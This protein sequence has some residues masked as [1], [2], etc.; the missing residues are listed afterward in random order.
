MKNAGYSLKSDFVCILRVFSV[1]RMKLWFCIILMNA[2]ILFGSAFTA[3]AMDYIAGVKGGYFI[4][5]AWLN[6]AGFDSKKGD[7]AL[8]GPVFSAMVTDDLSLSVAGLFGKQSTDWKSEEV[9]GS[10][11]V[12]GSNSFHVKRYDLDTAFNYSFTGNFKIFGG[13]KYQYEKIKF[14]QVKFS[15]DTNT[16]DINEGESETSDIDLVNHGPALGLGFSSFLG[17]KF[18][19]TANL[20]FLYMWGKMDIDRTADKYRDSPDQPEHESSEK[21]GVKMRIHGINFEPSIGASMGEGM[22][23][24]TIG[25]RFQWSRVHFENKEELE[26]RKE[27]LNDYLYGVFVSVLYPF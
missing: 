9:R 26:I 2:G 4:W 11:N 21:N 8:Y 18:F 25:I 1:K 19:F 3:S 12:N 24:F 22:P 20:S 27:Y 10:N 17:E 15:S 16:G 5:D 7:G 23:I 14:I 6:D 13:Y